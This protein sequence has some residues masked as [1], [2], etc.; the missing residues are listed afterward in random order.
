MK[1]LESRLDEELDRVFKE[2]PTMQIR[3]ARRKAIENLGLKTVDP[4]TK[5]GYVE[6]KSCLR[7][8]SNVGWDTVFFVKK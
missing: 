7:W 8:G 4:Y 6:P 5:K 1:E 2:N 3:G